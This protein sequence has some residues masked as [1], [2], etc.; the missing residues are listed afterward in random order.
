MASTDFS[1]HSC[2]CWGQPA[3]PSSGQQLCNFFLERFLVESP[4]HHRAMVTLSSQHLQHSPNTQRLF[5]LFKTKTEYL[6]GYYFS[7]SSNNWV[8]LQK[9]NYKDLNFHKDK[10]GLSYQQPTSGIQIQNWLR[11]TPSLRWDWLTDYENI[12][13]VLTKSAFAKSPQWNTWNWYAPTHWVKTYP[14]N[15]HA[16][17]QLSSLCV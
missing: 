2:S 13:A 14:M 9:Y 10:L 17:V 11:K 15:F 5:Q 6:K 16:S 8:R 7:F 4:W 3:E 12:L 1:L